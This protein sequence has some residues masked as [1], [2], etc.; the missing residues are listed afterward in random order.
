MA[1]EGGLN[2]SSVQNTHCDDCIGMHSGGI[3]LCNQETFLFIE[4]WM[5]KKDNKK[6]VQANVDNGQFK[7]TKL[8]IEW[9]KMETDE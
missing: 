9:L 5:G 2:G 3:S 6:S 7:K 8:I 1:N 4:T